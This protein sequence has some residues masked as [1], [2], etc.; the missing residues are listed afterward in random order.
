M[1]SR[2]TLGSAPCFTTMTTLHGTGK[3]TD[4]RAAFPAGGGIVVVWPWNG[5]DVAVVWQ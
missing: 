2:F 1:T 4:A 5:H 3:L